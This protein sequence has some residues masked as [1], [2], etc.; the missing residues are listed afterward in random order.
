MAASGESV[1]S[2]LQAFVDRII[3]ADDYPSG[4]QAGVGDFISIPARPRR[5][6]MTLS[7][8][9]FTSKCTLQEND[10]FLI[11]HW[12]TSSISM[13]CYIGALSM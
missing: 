1:R 12:G 11:S 7:F 13:C 6:N 9:A 3:P 10:L 2:T 4:W 5:S 8:T